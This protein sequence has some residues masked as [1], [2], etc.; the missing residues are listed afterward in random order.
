MA[1]GRRRSVEDLAELVLAIVEAVPADAWP[2]DEEELVAFA[3]DLAASVAVD[4]RLAD[5]APADVAAALE[6]VWPWLDAEEGITHV[7]EA[8]Q[9]AR[10]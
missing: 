9:V 6:A 8:E 10:V 5:V 4:C 7:I 1:R 2:D 3:L